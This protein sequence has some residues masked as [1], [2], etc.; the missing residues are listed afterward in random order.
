[1]HSTLRNNPDL[2]PSFSPRNGVRCPSTI[3]SYP[4]PVS[5]Q[6]GILKMAA[7]EKKRIA[8]TVASIVAMKFLIVFFFLSFSSFST[9]TSRVYLASLIIDFL[10]YVCYCGIFFF[11][12]VS[13][14]L[15]P[16]FKLF[17]PPILAFSCLFFYFRHFAFFFFR[18]SYLHARY[19]FWY[20]GKTSSFRFLTIFALR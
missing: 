7:L 12:Y 18:E 1:M 15:N 8:I 11:F 3:H 6:R 5:C 10:M 16:F 2:S 4:F 9:F 20:V 17:F 13:S 19:R 14:M